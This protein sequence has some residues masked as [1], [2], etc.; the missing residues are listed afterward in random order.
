MIGGNSSMIDQLLTIDPSK[1]CF[2]F[3]RDRILSDNYRGIQISQHNRYTF[4]QVIG[5]L[6][7]MYDLVG[8]NR[9]NIRTTDLSKRPTN[10]PEE[11][12]Y[13]KYTTLVNDKFGKSTQDSIRKNLFVDFHRMGLIYRYSPDGSRNGPY[14]RKNVKSVSLTPLAKDLIDTN[15]SLVEKYMIFSRAL[16]NLMLGLATD[17]FDIL[18]ELDYLTVLEYTFF[19]SFIRQKLNERFIEVEEVVEYVKEF[20]SLSRFQRDEAEKI[21]K[22]YCKPN[23]FAGNKKNK[24]DFHNWTNESMQ[25]YMLLNMTAYY[26]YNEKFQRIEFM[27]N[28]NYVFTSQEDVKKIKRSIVEKH[29]YFKEHNITKEL[30]YELHHIIPLLWARNTTEFFLLD[31][32]QNMLYIDA[33]KHAIITQSGNS[34]VKLRFKRENHN[35]I[36]SDPLLNKLELVDKINVR[37]NHDLKM[38]MYENNNNILSSF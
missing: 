17:F 31:K 26:T 32:W 16:D 33:K 13:A 25:V 2:L 34:H 30:G 20:R 4:E 29:R 38:M 12:M 22:E 19:V 7:I 15:K 21:V 6:T 18:A 23:N 24:R 28:E 37:Y 14:E 1:K 36:L 9:M 11:Y 8:M 35:I 27:V 10:T 5:M 3:L